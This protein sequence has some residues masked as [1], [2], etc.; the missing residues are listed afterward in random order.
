MKMVAAAKLRRAQ[1]Q[2]MQL[3]PYAKKINEI[4]QN[5]TSNSESLASNAFT[6]TREPKK[7]LIV[8]IT[9]DRGLCGPFNTNVIKATN[10]LLVDKYATQHAAKQVSF[11]PIGK[12]AFEYYTKRY[13]TVI[14][15]YSTLFTSLSFDKVKDAAEYAM[16]GFNTHEYDAVELV[17]NQFKNVATQIVQTDVFLPI[18]ADSV[19]ETKNI[20]KKDYIFEPSVDEIIEE[21]VPKSLKIKFYTAVLESNASEHGARMTAMDKATENA[22]EMLKALKIQYNRSR[23]ASITNEIL[24]IVA[25]AEALSA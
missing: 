4:L 19:V 2:A 24:E 22:G 15:D 11:L 21:I 14:G 25:G 8:V 18:S 9:S 6:Q 5:L 20:T 10:L 13:N 17:Y 16:N 23:Q 12:K 7:V 3:R 1:D